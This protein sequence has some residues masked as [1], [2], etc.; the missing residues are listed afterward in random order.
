MTKSPRRAGH[1]L[2]GRSPGQTPA[3]GLD[4]LP[5]GVAAGSPGLDDQTSLLIVE[6]QLQRIRLGRLAAWLFERGMRGEAV[7][8][9]HIEEAV[10]S[11]V[12]G[13]AA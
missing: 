7:A 8:L 2:P 13:L 5:A 11:V 6:L 4:L 9:Q 10:A 3:G 12:A 1:R